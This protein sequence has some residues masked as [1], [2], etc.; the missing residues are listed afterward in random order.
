MQ[1][2]IVRLIMGAVAWGCASC[3]GDDLVDPDPGRIRVIT[4]TDGVEP[5]PDGYTVT[6]DGDETVPV[7]ATASVEL[8]APAGEHTV[9]LAGIAPQCLLEGDAARTVLVSESATSNV[10]YRVRCEQT[11]GTL[12]VVVE[13]TGRL[14]DADGFGVAVD[15]AAPVSVPAN[16]SL[17]FADLEPGAHAIELTGL[18]LN[19]AVTSD[20]PMSVET[21]EDDPVTVTF[22]VLCRAGVERW[23]R[24]ESGST[25]DFTNVW[26]AGDGT[27]VVIGERSTRRGVEGLVLGFDGE[28]WIRQ[29]GEEDLRP[30]AVWGSAADDVYLVGYGFLAAAARVLHYDGS[31]WTTVH[32]FDREDVA[33]LGFESVWGSSDRDVF[34][35][36]FE[37]IGAFRISL[38]YR[39]DGGGWL[40][41]EVPGEVLPVLNDVWG[42]GATDVY[43][44]GRDEMVDPAA[45]V[46]LHYDG[47]TWSPVLQE[48]DLTLNGV[49][50]SSASDVFA[51]GFRVEQRDEQFFVT[52]EVWHFDGGA[53][54]RVELPEVGVLNEVW[55]T[56]GDDVYVVG[57]DGLILHYDGSAWAVRTQGSESLLG[58]WGGRPGEVLAVGIN[59]TI[60]SGVP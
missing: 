43:A 9:L 25:A 23:T 30:R 53:W 37:D 13:T 28:R 11:D 20:N 34:L 41:M 52:G 14:L 50:G 18:A 33:D 21:T 46:V 2:R 10:A 60:L 49:W 57:E 29:Y 26:S 36:G 42:S 31:E 27:A 4:A 47:A 56:G 48:D 3:G 35:V 16:G 1:S 55:G 32:D 24:V 6:L 17:V 19:C 51:V 22:A 54:S 8:D 40:R 58:V 44:V 38:I 12:T 59:G 5:D 39:F 45:G 15:G 7:G